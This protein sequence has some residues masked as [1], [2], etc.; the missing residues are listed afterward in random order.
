MN[1]SYKHLTPKKREDVMILRFQGK[2][3]EEIA[4]IIGCRA[5][6]VSRELKRNSI[7]GTYSAVEAQKQYEERR[8][9]CKAQ[10]KLEDKEL[11]DIVQQ[12]M[13]YEQWSPQQISERL[14]LENTSKSI[15]FNT[16]YCGI[17]AGLFNLPN[18]LGNRLLRRKGKPY[19]TKDYQENMGK[20]PVSNPIET[21]PIE[22]NN[23]M[24]LGDWEIDTVLG[25]QGGECLVTVVCRKSRFL[26]VKK[27]HNKTANYVN[28]ALIKLLS[29]LPLHSITPDRGKEFAKHAEVT[30]VLNVDFYFPQAGQPWQRGTNEN[31]NGLLREYFPKFKELEQWSNE[32]IQFVVDKINHRPRKCLGWRTPYE[33][34]FGKNLHL[35]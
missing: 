32:Y 15:S 5:C 33:V 13:Q 12:K 7:N 17:K 2:T 9:N 3:L 35:V 26:L 22:A 6:T 20:F 29:F 10:K 23:R 4:A 34:F 25:K 19:K 31:T 30:N 21:R 18:L 24:R 11:F 8:K 1:T 27:I 14:Q 28:N 16:I